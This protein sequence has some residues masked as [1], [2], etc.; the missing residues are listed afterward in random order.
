MKKL[1]GTS[2]RAVFGFKE[3][4]RLKESCVVAMHLDAGGKA[5]ARLI[6]KAHLAAEESSTQEG[7]R[8][9]TLL[10]GEVVALERIIVIASKCRLI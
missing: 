6:I 4:P 10:Y 1:Y 2:D 3:A 9:T 8:R 5:L 7:A